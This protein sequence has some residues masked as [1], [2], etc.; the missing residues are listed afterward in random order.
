MMRALAAA[1]A[2]ALALGAC[3]A[4]SGTAHLRH[5]TG[6]RDARLWAEFAQSHRG[7]SRRNFELDHFIPLCLGGGDEDENL[8]FQPRQTLVPYG[9]SAEA[10]DADEID[11]CLAVCAGSL[12]R[13]IAIG[14]LRS[15]W[16]RARDNAK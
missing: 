2:A 13:E 4:C 5:W 8:W 14:K 15:H 6:A 9:E 7:R 10:K 3:G 12:P 16:E 11:L 1:L